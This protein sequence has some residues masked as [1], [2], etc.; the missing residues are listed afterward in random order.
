[1]ESF[2]GIFEMMSRGRLVDAHAAD[3][4]ACFRRG[5]GTMAM[6]AAGVPAA[7]GIR[8][9]PR[10]CVLGRIHLKHSGS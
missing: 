1:M 8:L 4:I 3:G 2:A 7:A 9:T 5:I 6:G 10:G